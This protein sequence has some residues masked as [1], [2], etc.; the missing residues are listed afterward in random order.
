M[1]R[2]TTLIL[3]AL[4]VVGCQSANAGPTETAAATAARGGRINGGQQAPSDAP[5]QSAEPVGPS[6]DEV[7]K[8][9]TER[10]HAAAEEPDRRTWDDEPDSSLRNAS[11]ESCDLSGAYLRGLDLSGS[12]MR[13]ATLDGADLAEATLARADLSGA[14]LVGAD[15]AWAVLT[16]SNL[17]GADLSG[18]D[19]LHADLEGANLGDATLARAQLTLTWAARASFRGATLSDA[20]LDGAVLS[21]ADLRGVRGLTQDQ[22]NT[23]RWYSGASLP[24]GLEPDDRG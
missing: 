2:A 20:T 12:R 6:C 9:A 18:A 15:L 10:A 11:L 22:L 3:A 4:L 14:S 8:V 5:Q 24:R 19:L 23:T 13:R 7:R 17:A 21:G 1:I 16:Q